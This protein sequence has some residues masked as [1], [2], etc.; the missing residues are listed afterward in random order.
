[1]PTSPFEPQQKNIIYCF[2]LS[3]APKHAKSIPSA[4]C[5]FSESQS[6]QK[7]QQ[8]WKFLVCSSKKVS[9]MRFNLYSILGGGGAPLIHS[10]S[11]EK[12]HRL[13]LILAL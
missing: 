3:P 10:L 7:Q 8:R 1:M 5:V 12:I 9:G 2:R 13:E 4:V 11:K 6:H